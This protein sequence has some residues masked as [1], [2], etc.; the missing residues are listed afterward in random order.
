MRRGRSL[1]WISPARGPPRRLDGASTLFFRLRFGLR[2]S[3]RWHRRSTPVL[4]PGE[5]DMSTESGPVPWLTPPFSHL[6]A[7]HSGPALRSN[8]LASQ[9]P[10]GTSWAS[11]TSEPSHG[12][13][14]KSGATSA[15]FSRPSGAHGPPNPLPLHRLHPWAGSFRLRPTVTC[16]TWSAIWSELRWPPLG[17]FGRL[18]ILACSFGTGPAEGA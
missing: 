2:T 13:G 5:G 9:R 17:G 7:G 1:R 3:V 8:P 18:T 10:P 16:T 11:T 6:R 12:Q 4:M 15:R 14:R